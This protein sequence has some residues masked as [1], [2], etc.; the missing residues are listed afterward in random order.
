MKI[1]VIGATG[2]TGRKVMERA[3]E[4]GHEVV[5]IARRPEMI[6]PLKRL[7]IRQGDVFDESSL[8]RAIAGAEVVI[9]CISR[10]VTLRRLLPRNF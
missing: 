7:T 10:P 1:A 6:S 4:L 5:A 9:S 2:G 8:V 3:L